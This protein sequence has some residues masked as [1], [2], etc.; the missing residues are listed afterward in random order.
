M[1]NVISINGGV[2]VDLMG[3]EN[4]ESAGTRQLSGIGG[5]MD[6]LEGAYRSKGGK[7]FV[8]LNATHKKKD[9]TLKSNIVPCIAGGSTVSAP[10]TMIQYVA[11]EYGVAKLS[12]KTLRERAEWR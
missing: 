6:F 7:G 12:G 11:T 1:S 3:Q 2:E 10:R 8:C 4:G 5:Q 9:G